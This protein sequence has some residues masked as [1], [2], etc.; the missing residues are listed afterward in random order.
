MTSQTASRLRGK[1]LARGTR[2]GA[3]VPELP[4]VNLLPNEIRA[5]RGLKQLKVYLAGAVGVALI[6]VALGYVWSSFEAS[7]AAKD[8]EAENQRTSDLLAQQRKYAEVPVVLGQLSNA[9][10]ARQ[11]AMSTEVLWKDYLGA[12]NAVAPEGVAIATMTV[13]AA[14]PIVGPAAPAHVLQMPSVGKLTFTGSSPTLPDTVAWLDGLN[15]I[16]GFADARMSVTDTKGEG[17]ALYYEFTATVQMT[18]AA[19]AHRFDAEGAK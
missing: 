14:T 18:S 6:V 9:Y 4:Q 12:I 11:I 1:S 17:D 15:S 8:L 13:E 19:Y 16:Y 2:G 5:A 10:T 7:S 3:Q